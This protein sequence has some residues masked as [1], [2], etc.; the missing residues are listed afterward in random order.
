MHCLVSKV[1]TK[2]NDKMLCMIWRVLS[3][4]KVGISHHVQN[5]GWDLNVDGW[6]KCRWMVSHKIS[7]FGKM[8]RGRFLLMNFP[9]LTCMLLTNNSTY[10]YFQLAGIGLIVAGAI[11]QI[12][13]KDYLTVIGGQ[14]GSAAALLI[15]VGAIIFIIAFFGCCGAWKENYICV[16]IVSMRRYYPRSSFGLSNVSKSIDNGPN[17]WTKT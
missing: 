1:S 16:M 3:H 7:L 5:F 2:Y 8:Q 6:N 15:A 11:V 4:W 9:D 13:F 17:S 14:F 12:K 10:F